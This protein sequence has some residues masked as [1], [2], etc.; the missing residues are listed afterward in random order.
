MR[1]LAAIEDPRVIKRVLNH[2]GIPPA[3]LPEPSRAMD[4]FEPAYADTG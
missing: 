2:L 1:I 4:V 3:P